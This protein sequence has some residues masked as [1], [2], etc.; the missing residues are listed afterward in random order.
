VSS[1]LFSAAHPIMMAAGICHP[2]ASR[3][4][5]RYDA[6]NPARHRLDSRLDGNIQPQWRLKRAGH[7]RAWSAR[8][9]WQQLPAAPVETFGN[10]RKAAHLAAAT[11]AWVLF[12]LKAMAQPVAG[13]GYH[14]I[15]RSLVTTGKRSKHVMDHWTIHVV[16]LV[17]V[18]SSSSSSSAAAGNSIISIS[19]RIRRNEDAERRR[20]TSSMLLCGG[21]TILCIIRPA[22]LLFRL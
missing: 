17:V 18:I 11:A 15:G 4:S 8:R 19:I 16:A 2:S 1:R 13:T 3:K 7:Y 5:A 9:E 21:C 20:C 6:K 10:G 14:S 12:L 22:L